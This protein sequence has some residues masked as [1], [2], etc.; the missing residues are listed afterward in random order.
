M[1]DDDETGW[2]Q[3]KIRQPVDDLFKW[4]PSIE[5]GVLCLPAGERRPVKAL[6]QID[7]GAA[8][9]GVSQRLFEHLKPVAFKEAEV[10]HP[11][12]PPVIVPYFKVRLLLPRF[13]I[14][15]NVAVL[16]SLDPPHDVLLGRDLLAQSRF[17]V[18]F[19]TGVTTIQFKAS[20]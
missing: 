3:I 5:V 20:P 18:D 8:G 16:P 19:L 13:D 2:T 15:L 14:E 4:G 1:G 10:R 6:S 11:D 9:T 17:T 12:Q 7:T